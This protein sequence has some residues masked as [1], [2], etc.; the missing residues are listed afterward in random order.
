[1]VWQANILNNCYE[2]SGG[3]APANH[4][5]G[6]MPLYPAGGLPVPQT[7]CARRPNPGYATDG[8]EFLLAVA[9]QFFVTPYFRNGMT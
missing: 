9:T 6:A 7:P 2:L 8:N 3:Y 4:P 1:M 5:P